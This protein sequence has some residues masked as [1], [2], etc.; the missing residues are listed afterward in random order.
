MAQCR[1][2]NAA[3]TELVSASRQLSAFCDL[4]VP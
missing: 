1:E 2:Q 3:D 4:P